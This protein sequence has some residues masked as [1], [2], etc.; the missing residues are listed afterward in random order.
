MT[1]FRYVHPVTVNPD[2]SIDDA[3]QRMKTAGVRLLLVTNDAEEIIGLVTAKDIMG[4]KPIQIVQ[5]TR[6]QRSDIRVHMVMT[7]QSDITVLNMV[8]VRNAQVGHIIETL[9]QLERQHILV[10]EVNDATKTQR[11]IGLFSTSQISKHLARDVTEEMAPAHSLAEMLH[12]I[13]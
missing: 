8:S 5:E 2:M 7:S 9:R 3:L 13:R 4:E 11:V 1:D 6:V 10:V 12:Q